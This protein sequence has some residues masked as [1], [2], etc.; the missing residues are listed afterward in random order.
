MALGLGSSGTM[1]QEDLMAA[2]AVSGVLA[3][4]CIQESLI[5]LKI[6]L[7]EEKQLLVYPTWNHLQKRKKN[8]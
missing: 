3:G 7:E 1:P 6:N 5:Q 2:L 4:E 8:E